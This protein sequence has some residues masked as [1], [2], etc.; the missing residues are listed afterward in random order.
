MQVLQTM[1]EEF[2]I[3]L[4]VHEEPLQ[5]I[6]QCIKFKVEVSQSN[7]AIYALNLK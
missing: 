1:N 5:T 4:E 3:P 7:Y 6:D 2:P